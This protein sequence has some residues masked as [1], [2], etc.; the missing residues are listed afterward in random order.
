MGMG[1]SLRAILQVHAII[2]KTPGWKVEKL[3]HG[4]RKGEGWVFREYN[5]KGKMTGQL[6]R[7]SPG[8]PRKGNRPYW[9]VTS[10]EFGK[11]EPIF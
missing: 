5:E 6:I 11:S 2:G 4:K 10:L 9:R 7:W 8:S 1:F 3:R